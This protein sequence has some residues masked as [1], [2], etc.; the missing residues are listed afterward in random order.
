MAEE[1][2]NVVFGSSDWRARLLSNFAPTP[3]EL[4]GER[5][6]SVEGF[7]QGLKYPEGS[8]EQKR[9]F[10]LSGYEA[11]R[12][13]RKAPVGPGGVFTWR[14]RVYRVG[15]LEHWDLMRQALRAKFEQC[16]EACRALLAT[17]GLKLVHELP[18]DSKTIPGAVFARMLEEIRA[19][20]ER[21]D[22][23]GV[24]GACGR[25]RV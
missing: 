25:E 21:R 1:V 7:W 20:L 24:E 23:G 10:G 9:V 15:S 4:W 8:A 16:A 17:R 2:L 6:G 14:G 13:G 18:R 3:F 12:A 19:D 22:V 5:F 11:K